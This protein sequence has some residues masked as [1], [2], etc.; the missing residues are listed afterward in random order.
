MP[1]S[2][3]DLSSLDGSNGFKINGI[4]G[5]DYNGYSVSSPGDVNGDG[6]MILLLE[7]ITLTQMA[8]AMQVKAQFRIGGIRLQLI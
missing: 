3:L 8:I 5:G 1:K 6:S 4:D 7:H 2:I